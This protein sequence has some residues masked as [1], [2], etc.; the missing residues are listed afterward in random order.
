MF[1][2][3][4]YLVAVNGRD[5][6]DAVR[7]RYRLSGW[8][9][10]SKM[11]HLVRFYVP[12]LRYE[13]RRSLSRTGSASDETTSETPEEEVVYF[14]RWCVF[15]F[16]IVL[17]SH[18]P[19]TDRHS[20][21]A[22]RPTKVTIKRDETRRKVGDGVQNGAFSLC[23]HVDTIALRSVRRKEWPYTVGVLKKT[24]RRRSLPSRTGLAVTYD[25]S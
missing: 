25:Q 6:L 11:S 24:R 9:R 15:L 17:R 2:Y 13:R 4:G 1:L 8:W 12:Y 10:D 5:R 14:T 7:R 16:V 23:R 19:K 18:E 22:R 21:Y 3:G 20:V